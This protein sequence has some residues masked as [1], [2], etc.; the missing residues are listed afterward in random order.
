MFDFCCF[1]GKV[2]FGDD[3]PF[4]DLLPG[5]PCGPECCWPA[6]TEVTE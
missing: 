1:C 2:F 6:G 3:V 5:K 4:L